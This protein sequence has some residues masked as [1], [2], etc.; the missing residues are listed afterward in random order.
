MKHI[1][2]LLLLLTVTTTGIMAQATPRHIDVMAN[3]RQA[4]VAIY[5]QDG[6]LKV[7]GR[8]PYSATL[9]AD[10]TYTFQARHRYC[11]PDSGTLHIDNETEEL[12]VTMQPFEVHVQWEVTPAGAEYEFTEIREK[13]KEKVSHFD[14]QTSES[15]T[16]PGG[17]YK[18]VISK[19][20][21]RPYTETF[22]FRSDTTLTI[23][24]QLKRKQRQLIVAV[25]A[26]IASCHSVP[27]GISLSYGATYGVYL[28]YMQ[29]I[30]SN[31]N[32]DD[33]D[34]L[35]LRDAERYNYSSKRYDMKTAVVGYQYLYR[36]GMYI[37]LGAGYGREAFSWKSDEDGKRHF[38]A[39]DT[40]KR[41][42]L[43][44]GLGYNTGRLYLGASGQLLGGAN[45]TATLLL[46]VV[47]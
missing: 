44:A 28:R 1:F 15:A 26:G 13:S 45:G 2:S 39:P 7:V 11:Y 30:G 5:N 27:V 40:K 29:T 23:S 21:F 31:A 25:N 35:T 12:Q 14:G 10:S 32:G 3:V 33:F 19:R 16:L 37:Q 9:D 24:Q 46:G 20:H 36:C 38:Y 47:L 43:D 17:H 42:V 4:Q 6:S 22:D 41:L 34:K 8:T 18:M